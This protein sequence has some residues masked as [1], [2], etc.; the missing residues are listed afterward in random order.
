MKEL[1]E[2]EIEIPTRGSIQDIGPIISRKTKIPPLYLKGYEYTEIEQSTRN[3]WHFDQAIHL[4]HLKSYFALTE[5][6]Q[7]LPNPGT[8][9]SI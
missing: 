1:R 4:R 3:T 6:L 9:K 8:D 2:Q 7:H 5:E